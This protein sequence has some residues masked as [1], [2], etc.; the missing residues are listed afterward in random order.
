[1]SFHEIR[2]P[3]QISRG[4]TGGPERR[5]DIVVMG[6]GHEERNARWAHSRRNYNA[7]YGVRSL[8]D[9]HAVIAFFEERRGRLHGF[10]WKDHADWKSC[11]PEATLS[12]SDQQIGIGDGNATAFG[13]IKRYGGQHAPYD[14]RITKPVS[15][16]VVVAVAGSPVIEGVAFDVDVS[17]GLVHFRTGRLP[18]PGAIVT[19]GYAFD[20]PVR[21]DTDRLE[22]NLSGF[23]HGAIPAI[24][25]VEIRI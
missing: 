13:L 8:D 9:L 15:G 24:P 2:F 19:A 17:A 4:A 5:T 25:V 18:P 3:T 1:M 11:P 10:R 22:V 14:R 12:A 20:V 23:R 21:F 7:G 6:S 16:T